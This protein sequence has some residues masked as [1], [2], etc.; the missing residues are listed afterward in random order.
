M[1]R[2]GDAKKGGNLDASV[3]MGS[4]NVGQEALK[5]F[6]RRMR[7]GVRIEEA[8]ADDQSDAPAEPGHR[9]RRGGQHPLGHTIIGLFLDAVDELACEHLERQD[10]RHR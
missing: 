4:G 2:P 6:E 10:R 9:Q 1:P 7:D 3:W 8:M 5:W